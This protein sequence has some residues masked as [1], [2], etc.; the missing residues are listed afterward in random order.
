M[1]RSSLIGRFFPI[2]LAISLLSL[3]TAGWIAATVTSR[4]YYH[5]IRL[6]LEVRARL[7]KEMV[8][9]ETHS[10]AAVDSLC[11]HLSL[12]ADTRVTVIAADGQVL[13]DSHEDPARMEN[14]A[15]R[16]EIRTALAG[17]VGTSQRYSPT[18]KQ[19]MIYLAIP[20]EENGAVTGAVRTSMPLAMVKQAVNGVYATVFLSGLIIALLAGWSNYLL[21]NHLRRQASVI[22]RG[23]ARFAE[24]HL[25]HKLIP[26]RSEELGGL[27]RTLNLMAEQ[28]NERIETITRQRGELEAVLSSMVEGVIVFDTDERILNM[29]QAAAK[30]LE[31]TQPDVRGRNVQ[32]VILNRNFQEF[33]RRIFRERRPLE[34]GISLR[35]GDLF[36]QA[37]GAPLHDAAGRDL[38]ALVVIN[39]VTKLRRLE[40]I[41]REFVANVSHELRTPITA[42][43][44]FVETLRDGAAQD[45]QE[46][47][48]FLDIISRHTE[49]LH[50][51]IEDLLNLSRLEQETESDAIHLKPGH[52]R[53][54][55]QSAIS[56]CEHKA[57]EKQI[58][59]E[60][61]DG[62]EM[63][64]KI[65][66][67]LLEQALANLLDNAINYSEPGS[68]IQ[69]GIEAAEDE[70]VLY[71]RDQGCGIETEH[72]PRIFE[73]FYRV[74]K[75]RSRK[76]GGTGLGLAIVKH[77]ALAHRGRVS[78]TS[79]LG[80]GST[81]RIH[82]P[83]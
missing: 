2:Y 46:S 44:G 80:Q 59:C 61:E 64:A 56:D 24:G 12:L 3:L 72:L 79:S 11:K 75:T 15:D 16:P 34:A 1:R 69:I 39:D 42:I 17:K 67:P 71:V 19:S 4:L 29:N 68:S 38:G 70:W 77:I 23:A 54:I 22:R 36:V 31:T 43:R 5:Q 58:R 6:D 83:R 18:L 81:F 74:D 65:N 82:L 50:A 8:G 30:L 33:V 26:P 76:Q 62:D 78:V 51:I 53:E 10:S 20:L 40:N 21:L 37:Q 63:V 47:A 66:A 27:A 60:L 7:L 57:H 55:L 73:R 25:E 28:L 41:R 52:L 13:G 48:R 35:R 45:P 14:H 49:R 9:K 32:E